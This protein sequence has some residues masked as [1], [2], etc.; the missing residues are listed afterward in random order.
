MKLLGTL[1]L[2]LI[3]T[4]VGTARADISCKND[5]D[6]ATIKNENGGLILRSNLFGN[7]VP[8]KKVNYNNFDEIRCEG[9]DRKQDLDI[10]VSLGG[11]G[12]PNTMFLDVGNAAMGA[13]VQLECS[14]FSKN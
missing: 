1:I 14:G 6:W 4:T 12:F 10:D 9:Y 5:H 11:E 2:I 8:C 13:N 7:S 3:L